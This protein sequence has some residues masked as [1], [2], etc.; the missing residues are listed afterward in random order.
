MM[1][2][3][4]DHEGQKIFSYLSFIKRLSPGLLNGS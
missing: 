3:A 4:S 1:G 2:L